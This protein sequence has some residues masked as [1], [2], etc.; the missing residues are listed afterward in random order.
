MNVYTCT[1][2]VVKATVAAVAL[3][4][5]IS[6]LTCGAT[7]ASASPSG[8]HSAVTQIAA[9][10][11]VHGAGDQA[12]HRA[13]LT[14]SV[15]AYRTANGRNAVQANG[16]LD[17]RAQQWAEHLASTG[18]FYHQDMWQN[19]NLASSENLVVD[20]NPAKAVPRWSQSP[21]HNE[22]MLRP[23]AVH[24]GHGLAKY[25]TGPYAGM[26]VIVQLFYNQY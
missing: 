7:E 14:D 19:G 6:A 13:Q 24:V 17:A 2:R 15:N 1:G 8:A 23:N 21:V 20:S 11:A 16:N 9:R 25:E 18:E 22:N 5:G 26:W 4:V 3:G 12:A 10:H